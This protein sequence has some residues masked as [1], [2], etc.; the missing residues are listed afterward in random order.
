[1][2]YLCPRLPRQPAASPH[3][4]PIAAKFIILNAKFLVLNTQFLVFDTQFLVLRYK[5][6]SSLLTSTV[7]ITH[8]IQFAPCCLCKHKQPSP[9]NLED[10]I[11]AGCA[12]GRSM[13]QINRD[14]YQSINQSIATCKYEFL[15]P[16]PSMKPEGVGE[17]IACVLYAY[18][19]PEVVHQNRP[20]VAC[21]EDLPD[22]DSR[23]QRELRV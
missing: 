5:S 12:A 8:H 13:D 21:S 15:A 4:A 10:M 18:E 23:P 3:L 17:V 6:S 14:M 20:P 9:E 19:V 7:R 1:M 11:L 2:Y 16:D 22:D